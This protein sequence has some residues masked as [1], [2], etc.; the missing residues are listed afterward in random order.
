MSRAR[1]ESDLTVRAVLFWLPGGGDRWLAA[2]KQGCGSGPESPAAAL[3]WE[4]ARWGE[5]DFRPT[6]DAAVSTPAQLGAAVAIT[7]L[8][9]ILPFARDEF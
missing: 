3:M 9:G 6:L 4:V 5:G 2:R 8:I 1:W 7:V